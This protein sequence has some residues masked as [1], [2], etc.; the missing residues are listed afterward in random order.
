MEHLLLFNYIW[1]NMKNNNKRVHKKVNRVRFDYNL[2]LTITIE[3]K[4][5]LDWTR[6]ECKSEFMT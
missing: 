4:E 3:R 2:I 6:S 1:N 5:E